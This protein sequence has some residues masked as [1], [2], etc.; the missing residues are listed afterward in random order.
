MTRKSKRELE[1]ALD[2]VARESAP[3]TPGAWLDG[4]LARGMDLLLWEEPSEDAVLASER[5]DYAIYVGPED[6]PDWLDAETD[7]PVSLDP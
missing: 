6:L 7:L 1:R 5:S 2:D 3:C 4:H